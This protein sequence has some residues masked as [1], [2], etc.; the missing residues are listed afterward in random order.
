MTLYGRLLIDVFSSTFLQRRDMVER[1][2]DVKTITLQRC[3]DAVCLLGFLDDCGKQ[4][5]SSTFKTYI[6][7]NCI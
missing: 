4:K 1:R 7:T 6:L 5:Y 2:R 3:Y